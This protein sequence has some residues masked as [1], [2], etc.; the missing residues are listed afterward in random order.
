MFNY[1]ILNEIISSTIVHAQDAI[2]SRGFILVMLGAPLNFIAMLYSVFPICGCIDFYLDPVQELSSER[3]TLQALHWYWILTYPFSLTYSEG[4][5]YNFK[6]CCHK[7]YNRFQM[8]PCAE[9]YGNGVVYESKDC[10]KQNLCTCFLI[11]RSFL[12]QSCWRLCLPTIV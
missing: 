12:Y 7:F 9:G 4:M 5:L 10:C 6:L 3:C 8:S 2:R 1:L 11:I